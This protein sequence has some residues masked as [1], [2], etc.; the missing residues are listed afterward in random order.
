MTE[1]S[2]RL[3]ISFYFSGNFTYKLVWMIELIS[4]NSNQ[5]KDDIKRSSKI[6]FLISTLNI[7]S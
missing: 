4:Q 7:C 6:H 3:M 1:I 2:Y 5:E